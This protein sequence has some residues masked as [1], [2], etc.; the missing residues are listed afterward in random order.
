MKVELNSRMLSWKLK[1]VWPYVPFLGKSLETGADLLGVTDWIDASVPGSIHKDLVNSGIIAD[2]YFEKN[3]LLCEWVENRWWIYETKIP[4]KQIYKGKNLV[5]V[6]KGVDY[7][8]HIYFNNNYICEHEGM[9]EPIELDITS[10]FNHNGDN[11]LCVMIENAPDEMG[12]I[13][14]TS[15]VHTQKSRFNY[16]WDWST[17][18]VNLGIWDDVYLYVHEGVTINDVYVYSGVEGQKGIVNCKFLICSKEK[19]QVDINV[20]LS[21]KGQLVDQK[22]IKKIECCGKCIYNLQF[23][24][25]NPHLWWPNGYGEQ[26]L[27]ELSIVVNSDGY[28]MDSYAQKI[29]I[30]QLCYMKNEC[31]VKDALPYLLS[32]NG[33]RIYIKGVNLVPIDHMYGAVEDEKYEILVKALKHA[34]INLVRIWG[35]GLIEKE[36]LY[37]LCDENGIMI[38]QEFIQ[39]SSGICNTPSVKPEFLDLLAKNSIAALKGRRNYT[40]LTYWSGGNELRGDDNNPATYEHKNISMLKKLVEKYDRTRL[41][42]P[43]SASGPRE[44]LDISP[45]ARGTNHDV[46]GPWKYGGITRH[47]ELFNKS[48]SLLHSEFGVDSFSNYETMARIMS[49]ENLRVSD[50]FNNQVWRHHGEWWDTTARDCEIFGHT[51]NLRKAILCSQYIQAE[52]LRYALTANRRRKYENSG[53]IIWQFNEAWPQSSGTNIYDYYFSTKPAYYWVKNSFSPLVASLKY[54]SLHHDRHEKFISELY[55]N[56]SNNKTERIEVCVKITDIYG[57][58]YKQLN[59]T[60]DAAEEKCTFVGSINFVPDMELEGGLFFVNIYSI[61]VRVPSQTYM[62]SV[63]EPPIFEDILHNSRIKNLNIKLHMQ[64][65]KLVITNEDNKMALFVGCKSRHSNVLFDDNYFT[66]MPMES[67]SLHLPED[68]SYTIDDFEVEWLNS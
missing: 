7:K 59:F 10:L 66:L 32:V 33:R 40:C 15:R 34:N 62:F 5:L 23:E 2:P 49:E 57:T 35:G 20:R 30:R 14:Y 21:Y 52:G 48:D 63:K 1:G 28:V 41:F 38:W 44:F 17:R 6:F 42:L 27:Y 39:S 65:S 50:V 51:D 18:L 3:S 29:G 12:Q 46:H 8:C 22:D 31:S 43:T 37:K 19:T 53:S 13:G 24:V 16:K 55:I 9:F 11:K 61:D 25:E 58:V 54:D 64:D 67:R 60:I 56:N 36:I 26:E 4:P 47:Y 68:N 45:E